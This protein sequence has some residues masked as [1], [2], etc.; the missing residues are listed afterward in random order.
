[1]PDK[2]SGKDGGKHDAGVSKNGKPGYEPRHGS[3][4]DKGGKGGKG[5]K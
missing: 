2:G 5:G 3:G 4:N 1:M